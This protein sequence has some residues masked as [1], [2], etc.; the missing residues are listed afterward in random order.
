MWV[1]TSSQINHRMHILVVPR[2]VANIAHSNQV[3][4]SF[5]F[6][7]EVLSGS[8]L[9]CTLGANLSFQFGY[10]AFRT[11]PFRNAVQPG[12]HLVFTI[13][14]ALPLLEC[15]VIDVLFL[16]GFG[17]LLCFSASFHGEAKI[18]T[19]AANPGH[20]LSLDSHVLRIIHLSVTS[21]RLL[22]YYVVI[23]RTEI[24]RWPHVILTSVLKSPSTDCLIFILKTV[25]YLI[26]LNLGPINSILLGQ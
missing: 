7:T 10:N 4:P 19:A 13:Q 22:F 21:G 20:W 9:V 23:K 14:I 17:F 1:N 24:D 11:Y 3:G 16:C 6:L 15:G 5:P 12:Q 2:V 18:C 26:K 25:T 8:D